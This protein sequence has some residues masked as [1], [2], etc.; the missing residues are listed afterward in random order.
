MFY[1][2]LYVKTENSL[3]K[4]MIQIKELIEFAKKHHLKALAITD[5]NLYGA[6]EFYRLCKQEN[7]KPII[8][9]EIIIKQEKVLLY[10]QNQIG[11]Q[12]L[13]KLA[14]IQSKQEITLED[15]KNDRE[16][17]FCIIPFENRLSYMQYEQIFL[18]FIGYTT[19]TE[20]SQIQKEKSIYIQETLCLEKQDMV[21]I[22][23]LTAIKE[24]MPLDA[25]KITKE[26]YLKL[27]E[28]LDESFLNNFHE[29]YNMCN[30][31]IVKQE[32]LLPIY[33]C[34]DNLDS[35][36]YLKKL[37]TEGMRK[38]FG[39][40]VN[41]IYIE[42]L[43]YE[44]DIIQKMDFCN[45]FL[46]V[47]DYVNYAKTHSILV[48]PGRGSAA[49]SLV[50]YVLQIT[51]VDPIQYHL[52]F[53]RFLNPERITMPDIDIDFAYDRREEVIQYCRQKYGEKRVAG[54]ITFGTLG[55][56]QIVR[57]VGRVMDLL[58]SQINQLC[59]LIDPK[60]SLKENYTENGNLKAFFHEN[61]HMKKLYKIASKLEGL[62]RHTSI[63]AAG[64]IMCN[65]NLD[66]IIPLEFHDEMYLTGYSMEYLEELGLLKMDFLALKT[67]TSIQNIMKDVNQ[68]NPKLTFDQI[69]LGNQEA[70]Q[71]FHNVNT[72]GIFQFESAGMMNFL[73]KFKPTT[74]E[75]IFASLALYRPGPMDNIDHFIK[76]KNGLEPIDYFHPD[77]IPILKPTYG[78]L[79]YQEQIMQVAS[80]MAGYSYG[81]ADVLRRAM[82]KKKEEVLQKEKGKFI[83]NSIQRG[84]DETIS[85]TVYNLILKFASY[86]FNRSHSVAYAIIAYKM[87]YLK[88]HYPHIFMK[89]LLTSVIGSSVDTKEY[90]DECK[91]NHIIILPPDINQS[92][93]DY[94]IENNQI[95]YPFTNIKDIGLSVAQH[96]L[97]VRK[98][99]L[100]LDIY[101]FIKRTNRKI[102]N[103][104]VIQRLIDAG[105]FS[106]FHMNQKTLYQS[107]DLILNYG[108]LIKDLDE[109]YTLKP[110]IEIMEE[111]S[112]RELMQ[113]ELDTFGFYLSKHP[114]TEYRLMQ[115]NEILIKEIA[116][117]FD[118]NISLIGFVDSI[119]QVD[120]KKGTQMGFMQCSDESASIDAVLFPNVYQ[121][122]DSI[123]IGSIVEIYG[124]VER[125][126]DKYQIVVKKIK[127]LE[128]DMYEIKG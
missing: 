44:L 47:W 50:S 86:G 108:E 79:I 69:P 110:E 89:S 99:G 85:E 90:I 30:L 124:H 46:V 84:Y 97:E 62:K 28:E 13:I 94:K 19:S 63:H 109:E 105:S 102:V 88:A 32:N 113:K 10:C 51:D 111:Y 61:D 6:Y 128:R 59:K 93:L 126:F 120:T 34:P 100:F 125:R 114:V 92:G 48:G 12:N 103:K 53:E 66:E 22:P 21:Y 17:L 70:M 74:F 91:L 43:K 26:C 64:I 76:R 29:I 16:G 77:L 11:Y 23:Y 52:L 49:G 96:I 117:Y 127:I 8:G 101:D 9:L 82:S 37:C 118:Q 38:R 40:S 73:H 83:K 115:N 75:D 78:I 4:S 7:I 119:R 80:I 54:I 65:Q 122:C 1:I 56:K 18:T 121:T 31:E 60:K 2:P 45:Y 107:L 58:P 27:P 81:E 95:R 104:K 55:A 15:L 36:T 112:K 116:N 14:T 24:G 106:S 68:E 98:E 3:L 67:L 72:T 87:A 5:E 20:K 25:I 42:R 33:P 39:N 35:Y 123:M 41:R 57:D 71:I